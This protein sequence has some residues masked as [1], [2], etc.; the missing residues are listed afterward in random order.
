[1]QYHGLPGLAELLTNKGRHVEEVLGRIVSDCV[2]LTL[3]AKNLYKSLEPDMRSLTECCNAL[4]AEDSKPKKK[5][6]KKT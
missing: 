3:V 6:R 2:D 1:M 4:E 5:R